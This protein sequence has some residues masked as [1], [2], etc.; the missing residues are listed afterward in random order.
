[1]KKMSENASLGHLRSQDE[2]YFGLAMDPKFFGR[3]TLNFNSSLVQGP[4]QF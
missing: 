3:V 1:M 2:A 4:L